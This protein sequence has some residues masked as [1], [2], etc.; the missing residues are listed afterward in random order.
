MRGDRIALIAGRRTAWREHGDARGAPVLIVHGAWGGPSSTLWN[1]P[2]LRWQAP[3]DGLRLIHYDRRCAGHSDYSGGDFTLSDLARDAVVLLD[4]LQI[5]RAAIVATSAGGPI[6]I[7]LALDSPD[8]VGAL[9]LLNTG[10]A[11]MHPRPKGLAEPWSGEVQDRIATVERRLTM[12]DLADREGTAAAVAAT[13]S[14]WRTPPDPP[15]SDDPKL[16][17]AR[18]HRAAALSRLPRGELIRLA[19]GAIRNMRAQRGVNLRDQLQR[20]HLPVWI[21]HGDADTTVP[22]DFGQ[23]LAD[24]IPHAC[25]QVFPDTGHGLI[26]EPAAQA[27][28]GEWLRRA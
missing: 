17:A 18:D 26:V 22:I 15:P 3:T 2:R 1:G 27:V 21:G 25:F 16:Q 10:A 11:L 7:R 14:E 24:A 20:L 8:R 6:A 23:A 5:D 9:A 12:L 4:H 19:D 13:E 28:L